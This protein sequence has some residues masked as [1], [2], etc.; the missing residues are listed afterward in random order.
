MAGITKYKLAEQIQKLVIGGFVPVGTDLTETEIYEGINQVVNAMIKAD[1]L[2]FNEQIGELIP[3]GGILAQYRLPVSSYGPNRSRATLPAMPVKLRRN[4]GVFQVNAVSPEGDSQPDYA[5]IPLQTGEGSLLRS[6]RP[7]L[8]NLGGQCGYESKGIFL[9]FTKNLTAGEQNTVY[10]DVY[11]VLMDVS[12]YEEWETLPILPE[13][14]DEIIRR[15]VERFGI[16]TI[17]DKLVDV[18]DKEQQ[19]IPIRQQEQN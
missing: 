12:A 3:N 19:N 16:K 7:I 18:S 9:E 8:S 6:Q 13:M 1:H 10:V 14:E 15:L 17:S 5:Y 4:M 2:S 11:I